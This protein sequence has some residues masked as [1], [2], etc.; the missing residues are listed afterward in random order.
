MKTILNKVSI[1]PL[2]YIVILV[3]LFT[4]L[5]K[6]LFIFLSIIIIH[7]CGHITGALIF[8]WH[9]EK[10][11]IMPFGGL[12]VFNEL[13]NR[14]LYEEFIILIMGPL[15]QTIYFIIFKDI[16]LSFN[17]YN[18]GLFLFNF[19]PIYPLDGYK[20]WNL[21][22]SYFMPYKLVLKITILI[23]FVFLLFFIRL[24][25]I[26]LLIFLFLLIGCIKEYRNID[27]I[28]NKFLLERYYYTFK[29]K[30]RKIINNLN[31]MYRDCTHL[32]KKDNYMTEKQALYNKYHNLTNRWFNYII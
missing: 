6:E 19:L 25:L 15:F 27:F 26:Y 9:I 17:Y 28:Y 13:L 8:K 22:F 1:N 14:P 20:F 18:Y 32:I 5:F 16:N 23:S 24:D 2:T 11:V 3:S 30:R 31:M 7:E 29:F 12:T 21:I 10:V 4:G